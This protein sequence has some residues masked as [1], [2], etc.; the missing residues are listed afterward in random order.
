MDGNHKTKVT[1]CKN[2][3]RSECLGTE[4]KGVEQALRSV[5]GWIHV[6]EFDETWFH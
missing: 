5:S 6:K 1:L 3:Q 4:R 2:D